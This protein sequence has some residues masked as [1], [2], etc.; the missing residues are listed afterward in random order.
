MSV[1]GTKL[2]WRVVHKNNYFGKCCFS[3]KYF[4]FLYSKKIV[5][6]Q[7]LQFSL[8]QFL[9]QFFYIL[10]IF[11]FYLK[12]FYYL[13]PAIDDKRIKLKRRSQTFHQPK[14]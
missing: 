7:K 5:R 11:K 4:Y 10:Y 12:L 9:E 3:Q 8:E 1:R 2:I 13:T 14:K 6:D